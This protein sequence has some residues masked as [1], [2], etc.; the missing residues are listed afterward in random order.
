MSFTHSVAGGQGNLIAVSLKSPNFIHG[1]QGWAINKD[2][3]AEFHGIILPSGQGVSV[4]IQGTTPTTTHVGDLWYDTSN[5]LLLHQWNGTS[6]VASSIGTGAIAAGA[7]T[8]TLLASGAVGTSNIQSAAI[9]N[10][11]LAAAAVGASNIQNGAVTT[12][13]INAAAG[14]L[15]TQIASSTI[16]GSNI[17]AGTITGSNI[18]AATI[19][20]GLIAADAI[21]AGLIAAGAIDGFII[22]G[23]TING[24]TINAADI[25]IEAGAGNAVLVYSTAAPA[26][27]QAVVNSNITPSG[28]SHA[29]TPTAATTTGNAILISAGI[30]SATTD[31]VTGVT[32]SKSNTYTRIQTEPGASNGRVYQ[33]IALNTTALTTS[34]TITVS[35]SSAPSSFLGVQACELTNVATTSATDKT[36][37][38]TGT[39]NT[40]I[41][42]GTLSASPEVVVGSWSSVIG[43]LGIGD[44]VFATAA[45]TNSLL[46]TWATAGGTAS[47]TNTATS[48]LIGGTP[49]ACWGALV[50]LKASGSPVL[51]ASIAAAA[52]TDT[53]GNAYKAGVTCYNGSEYIQMHVNSTANAPAVDMVTAASSEAEH[54]ALYTNVTNSGLVNEVLATWLV[55]PGSTFD[56]KQADIALLSSAKNGSG[57]ASGQLLYFTPTETLIAFWDAAGFHVQPGDGNTYPTGHLIAASTATNASPQ[58]INT[59]TAATVTGCTANTGVLAYRLKAV[60]QFAGSQAAGTASFQFGTSGTISVAWGNAVFHDAVAGTS[61]YVARPTALSPFASPTLSTNNW[62]CTMDGYVKFTTTGSVSLQAFCSVAADTFLIKNAFLELSPIY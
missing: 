55:G 27:K 23:V 37:V 43:V 16:E 26:F 61:G 47:L 21:V 14:I 24:N 8:N 18:Q 36:A 9:T 3:T 30:G 19:T 59:T 49:E 2:G 25:N 17:D 15:G 12:T 42:T 1:S 31:L 57:T 60:I 38:N 6:W 50:S 53:Y 40:S 29:F 35:Y 5:G 56:N 44:S 13:Q 10:A 54:G 41:S 32:D 4:F 45:S 28:T 52:G 62:M 46:T 20:S 39:G 11:L 22:N 58:T 34:D 7:I 33:Y 51:L 48:H